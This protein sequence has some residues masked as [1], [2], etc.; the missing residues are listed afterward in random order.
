MTPLQKAVFALKE[1][2]AKLQALQEKQAEPIAVV[3]M[4]CR[5]PGVANDGAS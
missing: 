4:A 2:K 1:T 3:G 5:F